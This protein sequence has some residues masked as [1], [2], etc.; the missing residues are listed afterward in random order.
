M[1]IG[2]DIQGGDYAPEATVKGALLASEKLLENEVLVLIGNKDRALEIIGGEEKVPANIEFVHTDTE[3]P[4]AANPYKS[5]VANPHASI[6]LGFHLLKEKQIDVFSSA[7]NTGAMMIGA[8]TVVKP[9][10]GVIRPAIAVV[11]PKDENNMTLMLDVGLN[12]DAKPDVLLQYGII[13]SLYA[14]HVF[15]TKNPQVGLLNIGSEPGKGNLITKAAY[16]LL[17]DCKH[18]TFAG[19]VE[20]R[21]FYTPNIPDVVVTDGFVGNIVL[22]QA[23]A[24]YVLLRKAKITGDFFE[25]F[26]YE[27]FGGSPILGVNGN[28]LIGH[29]VSS[30]KAIMNM[31]LQSRPLVSANLPEKFKNIFDEFED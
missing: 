27:N 23:E 30:P 17:A 9:I 24:F 14:Q 3:I 31:V 13:G 1:R 18:I 29:G 20:G 2:L 22:K 10:S 28:V 5:Y 6:P 21:D 16:E 4:M 15:G 26:N 8:S 11:M 19:N 25:R 7:G 12:P